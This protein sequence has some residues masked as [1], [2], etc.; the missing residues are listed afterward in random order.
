MIRLSLSFAIAS[1]TGATQAVP[2]P[3]DETLSV[4][5]YLN[6][7][8]RSTRE[9]WRGERLDLKTLQEW[10]RALAEAIDEGS[11]PIRPVDAREEAEFVVEIRRCQVTSDR[12]FVMGGIVETET[13]S[14]P[15]EMHTDYAPINLKGSVRFFAETLRRI[16]A[17]GR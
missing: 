13:T 8:D 10:S 12:R 4:Y 3:S 2:P 17:L 15:F 7:P 5:F 14:E 11:T 6:H 9:Y 16:S 1:L